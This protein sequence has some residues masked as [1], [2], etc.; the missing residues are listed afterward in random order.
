MTS[1]RLLPEAEQDL[2]EAAD[3]LDG[4]LPG[5]GGRFLDAVGRSLN[6]LGH[7]PNVGPYISSNLRKLVVRR[8]PYNLIYRI[9]ADEVLVLAIAHHRRR[10]SFWTRRA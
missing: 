5:L 4:R 6:R 8:F 7:N 9:D 3:F 10:P 2:S 1:V